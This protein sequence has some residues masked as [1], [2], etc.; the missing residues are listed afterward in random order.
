MSKLL[1]L[2]FT[3]KHLSEYK[4]ETFINIGATF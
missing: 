1:A 3:N 2:M 4:N